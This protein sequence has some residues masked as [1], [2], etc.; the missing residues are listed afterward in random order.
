MNDASGCYLF[1]YFFT[2]LQGKHSSDLHEYFINLLWHQSVNGGDP[3][4]SV[5][6]CVIINEVDPGG[7]CLTSIW[8]PAGDK[9]II[10][11]VLWEIRTRLETDRCLIPLLLYWYLFIFL[12]KV[13]MSDL[14]S[15]W[16][17]RWQRVGSQQHGGDRPYRVPGAEGPDAGGWDSA[18][19]VCSGWCGSQAEPV[20]GAAG[21]GDP[22]RTHQR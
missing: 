13:S 6:A 19:Q 9:I 21:Y 17:L 8:V 3:G 10:C 22:Q 11:S 18:A 20:G 2:N 16:P 14:S 5:C 15:C 1:I 7:R 4:I 12:K